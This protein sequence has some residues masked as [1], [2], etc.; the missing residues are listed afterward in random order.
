MLLLYHVLFL[1]LN[2]SQLGLLGVQFATLHQLLLYYLPPVSIDV[3]RNPGLYLRT[4]NT[5]HPEYLQSDT[6]SIVI[7]VGHLLDALVMMTLRVLNHRIN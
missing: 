5:L 7:G 4:R 2:R 1:L 3:S 6:I